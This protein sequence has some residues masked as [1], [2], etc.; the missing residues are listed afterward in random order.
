MKNTHFRARNTYFYFL[1]FAIF[2]LGLKFSTL[3]LIIKN[4]FWTFFD[5]GIESAI[6]E[7]TFL[8]KQ[9]IKIRNFIFHVRVPTSKMMAAAIETVVSSCASWLSPATSDAFLIV[10]H[11]RNFFLC[12]I[13]WYNVNNWQ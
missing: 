2:A 8:V 6:S 9:N 11:R 12:D 10:D 13:S 3:K 1:N 4:A 5:S 7:S